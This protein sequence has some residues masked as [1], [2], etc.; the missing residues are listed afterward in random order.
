M[1]HD[2]IDW[3][4]Q[5]KVDMGSGRVLGFEVLVRWNNPSE[6]PVPA[7]QLIHAVEQSPLLERFTN[8]CL[9]QVLGKFS[10]I[11]DRTGKTSISIILSA[12]MLQ[13]SIYTEKLHRVITRIGVEHKTDKT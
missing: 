13:R 11:Q 10:R 6:K 3:H 2:A 9:N 5:P 8:H 12:G 7:D 4:W 1:S